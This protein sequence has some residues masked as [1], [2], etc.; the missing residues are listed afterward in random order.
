MHAGNFV[1]RA[2]GSRHAP[3][4]PKAAHDAGVLL[5]PTAA[6]K[7]TLLKHA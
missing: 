6:L 5:K 1:I 4:A 2:K 3:T 7:K